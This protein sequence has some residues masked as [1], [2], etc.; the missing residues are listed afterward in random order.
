MEYRPKIAI[1]YSKKDKL[2]EGISLLLLLVLWLVSLRFYPLLPDVIAIHFNGAGQ[3][4]G[5]GSRS[6]LFLLPL[7]ATIIYGGT[8]LLNRHPHIFNYGKSITLENAHRLYSR[9]TLFIRIVKLLVLLIFLIIVVVVIRTSLH[10][11][12]GPGPL[13]LPVLLTPLILA[14]GWTLASMWR[15]TKTD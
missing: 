4:D 2:L 7:L 13:F 15:E 11:S 9:A 12:A 14:T 6:S 3:T 1:H 5:Y 8:T 10:D